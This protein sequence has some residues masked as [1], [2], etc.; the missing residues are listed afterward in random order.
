MKHLP[1]NAAVALVAVF[2]SGCV[3]IPFPF[4]TPRTPD[5]SGRVVDA[6]TRLPVAH[7]SVQ[8]LHGDTLLPSPKTITDE[9]GQF[10]LRRT[11]NWHLGAI[12]GVGHGSDIN[13]IWP[14]GPG[15]SNLH[16][17]HP[18]YASRTLNLYALFRASALSNRHKP[19]GEDILYY[20]GSFPVGDIS[21]DR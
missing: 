2:L 19:M 3:I 15:S 4:H 8:F 12:L 1:A 11:R 18:G 10:H 9:T 21:L 17:E 14:D 5:I 7:A 6:S 13:C 20:H 16:I